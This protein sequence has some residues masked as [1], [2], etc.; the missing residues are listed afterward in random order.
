MI[1][2]AGIREKLS[3]QWAR[4]SDESTAEEKWEQI[5]DKVS[6]ALEK[7]AK[8]RKVDSTARE[9]AA[10]LSSC[11]RQIVFFHLYP[12]LDVNVSKARNHLLKSPWC[13]HPKTGLC[14][15][16]SDVITASAVAPLC[17]CCTILCGV[18]VLLTAF[19][20]GCFSHVCIFFR[21]FFISTRTRLHPNRPRN[22]RHLQPRNR[23]LPNFSLRRDQRL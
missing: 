8:K 7:T 12:R 18:V 9:E 17:T 13:I 3:N 5:K 1:P 23:P 14:V 2:H 4:K 22:R 16:G 20:F 6:E 10:G 19:S 15:C 21:S 11:I